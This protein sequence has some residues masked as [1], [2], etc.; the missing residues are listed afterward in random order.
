M[1]FLPRNVTL[2]TTKVDLEIVIVEITEFPKTPSV[3]TPPIWRIFLNLSISSEL[4]GTLINRNWNHVKW[5]RRSRAVAQNVFFQKN[6]CRFYENAWKVDTF[7]K[8]TWK[9]WRS[10]SL[11]LT[12]NPCKVTVFP[13]KVFT[14]PLIF[15]CT[16]ET[17]INFASSLQKWKS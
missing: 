15:L 14:L 12:L 4:W 5:F 11:H 6:L 3:A 7:L 2:T 1:S 8:V 13:S 10:K 16:P 9:L 17:P